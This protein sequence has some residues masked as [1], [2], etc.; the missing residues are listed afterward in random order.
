M[1]ASDV[2][3]SID[4]DEDGNELLG[5]TNF[6]VPPP[7]AVTTPLANGTGVLFLDADPEADAAA[8]APPIAPVVAAPA[9]LGG[10]GDIDRALTLGV[11]WLDE[12]FRAPPPPPLLLPPPWLL[13]PRATAT[14]ASHAPVSVSSLA[15]SSASPPPPLSEAAPDEARALDFN[16]RVAS[17][18]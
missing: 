5:T 8:D 15:P 6:P 14:L 11:V 12:R 17:A 3:H 13:A 2:R 18:P 9:N 1:S 16:A 4:T 7:L 10:G